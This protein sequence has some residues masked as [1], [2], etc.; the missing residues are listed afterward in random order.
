MH[1]HVGI[2]LVTEKSTGNGSS[3]ATHYKNFDELK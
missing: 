3:Y 2:A 1:V